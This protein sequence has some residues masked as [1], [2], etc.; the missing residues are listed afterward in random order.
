MVAVSDDEIPA[1]QMASKRRKD[2]EPGIFSYHSQRQSRMIS[3]EK[4]L[5]W[6]T[7]ILGS[8][9][10]RTK[11]KIINDALNVHAV[12]GRTVSEESV[13][14]FRPSFMKNQYELRFVNRCGSISRTLSTDCVVDFYPPVFDMCCSGDIRGLCDAFD[15]GSVSI[16][17][18]DPLGRGLLHVS[19]FPGF[20]SL[21]SDVGQY[22]AGSFQGDLCSWLVNRGVNADRTCLRG[23][24]VNVSMARPI[25][26]TTHLVKHSRIWECIPGPIKPARSQRP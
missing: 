25:P 11:S 1:A 8:I 9:S 5:C 19:T 7:G 10:L 2:K 12:H 13:I 3:T 26:L 6:Y 22:A 16:N 21:S 15:N 18:V 23:T 4:L 20:L 14:V 17:V 24:C